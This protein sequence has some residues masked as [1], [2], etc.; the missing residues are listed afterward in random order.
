[1]R[2][3]KTSKKKKFA[4]VAIII[5][6]IVALTLGDHYYG[7]AHSGDV[8]VVTFGAD[9]SF[10]YT[11]TSSIDGETEERGTIII[12]I[13][14]GIAVLM[15][16][17]LTES[18]ASDIPDWASDNEN[19]LF[20]CDETSDGNAL[21]SKNSILNNTVQNGEPITR[22]F[23]EEDVEVCYYVK[24]IGDVYCRCLA[25]V[26]GTIYEI[27]LFEDMNSGYKETF[28]LTDKTLATQ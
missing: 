11:M 1:M 9:G 12:S 16:C 17:D 6:S 2:T 21:S 22:S 19:I 7:N 25:D 24:S 23:D 14:D 5:I 10:T 15:A 20:M 4:I 18:T 8:P 27:T 26:D 13:Y 3:A 28:T